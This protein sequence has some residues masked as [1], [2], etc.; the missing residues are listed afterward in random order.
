MGREEVSTSNKHTHTSRHHRAAQKEFSPWF[1]RF[2]SH[3]SLSFPQALGF[4]WPPHPGTQILVLAGA[5]VPWSTGRV[6]TAVHFVRNNNSCKSPLRANSTV[7]HLIA[8]QTKSTNTFES[9]K[10]VLKEFAL[11]TAWI[12][13]SPSDDSANKP[14]TDTEHQPN[15]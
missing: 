4:C 9:C 6:C 1:Q 8:S 10:P 11:V 2:C 5:A 3:Y 7:V 12:S 13:S 15:P 14:S